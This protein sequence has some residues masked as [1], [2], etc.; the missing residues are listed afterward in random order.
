MFVDEVKI[1]VLS[2]KGGDG[3]TSFRH[4]K[5]IDRG[6]PDGGDGGRG[7]D[8]VFRATSHL[9]TLSAFRSQKVFQAQDGQNG[10]RKKKHGRNSDD[11]VLAVPPGTLIY[12]SENDQPI[13]ELLEGNQQVIVLKGGRGGFGNAHFTSST[14]QAPD[15]AELGEP[16]RKLNL[17]IEL[18]LI[19]DI[20]I[21]GMPSVGKS[22]LIK[23]ISNA[24]PKIADYPFT[25]LVP[26]LGVVKM[27][28]D[29][30]TVCDIPGLIEGAHLGKG[31]GDKFLR[32]VERTKLL[33][34]LLD[35]TNLHPKKDLDLINRELKKYSKLLA[36]KLQIIAIN[37]IDALPPEDSAKLEK[38]WPQ[39]FFISSLTH[40]GLGPL[41]QTCWQE[42]QKIP[43]QDDTEDIKVFQP[44]LE[45]PH[46]FTIEKKRDYFLVSGQRIE[47]IVKM[48]SWDNQEAVSRVYD[49]IK[50]MGIQREL[51]RQGA[52][53]GDKIK[54]GS[55]ILTMG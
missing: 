25:T 21:I 41:L 35:A 34:H 26:N 17:R 38:K 32:H 50:K 23:A 7:G 47:Q 36:E 27:G 43:K 8:V 18:K 11:L 55:R 3:L 10:G 24:Q 33:I 12:D 5:F 13:H 14:R 22:T 9:D 19:A 42:L 30:V 28:K 48:T 31:L 29:T 49:A 46:R 20:A 45:D 4:E 16:A 37:K 2:G 54:I 1:T 51:I 53:L 15:F 40:Q 52:C 6:G 39:A 44:H